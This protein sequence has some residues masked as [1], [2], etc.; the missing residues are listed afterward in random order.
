MKTLLIRRLGPSLGMG[1]NNIQPRG[2]AQ[3][4]GTKFPGVIHMRLEKKA[5]VSP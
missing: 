5:A 4:K 2:I 3:E 1:A